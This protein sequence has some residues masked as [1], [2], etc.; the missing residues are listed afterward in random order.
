[1]SISAGFVRSF[2]SITLGGAVIAAV[3]AGLG[4]LS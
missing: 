3:S 1:M 2:I 4:A